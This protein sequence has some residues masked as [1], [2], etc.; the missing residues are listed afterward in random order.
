MAGVPEQ[1][2]EPDGVITGGIL[3]LPLAPVIVGNGLTEHGPF[4]LMWMVRHDFGCI[5]QRFCPQHRPVHRAP[6]LEMDKK[7]RTSG[8]VPFNDV[9][10]FCAQSGEFLQT[11]IGVDIFSESEDIR[12]GGQTAAVFCP[13]LVK[14]GGVGLAIIAVI[15]KEFFCTIEVFGFVGDAI[16][17]HREGRKI[18][19]V[20]RGIVP[21]DIIE[22]DIL[23]PPFARRVEVVPAIFSRLGDVSQV[24]LF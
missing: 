17:V 2:I 3:N 7:I 18:N 21:K 15:Q 10:L 11:G 22:I 23:A 13:G 24:L 20:C 1:G 14:I 16:E 19:I 6:L 8:D 12:Q 9:P 5:Q 4:V